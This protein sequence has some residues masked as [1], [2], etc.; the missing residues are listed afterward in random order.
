MTQLGGR[1][2]AAGAEVQGSMAA[3]SGVRRGGAWRGRWPGGSGVW[4]PEGAEVPSGRGAKRAEVQG[5]IY[6][7]P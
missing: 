4:G 3:A 6:G 2:V 7:S 5:A 1:A